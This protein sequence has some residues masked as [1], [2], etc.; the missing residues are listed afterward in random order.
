MSWASRRRSAYLSGVGIFLAVVIGI[1][2]AIWLYEAPTCFDGAQNQGETDIDK[3]GPCIIL[4]A[5]VL[6]P[7]S[8][9]WARSFES[10]PSFYSA[11]AYIENINKEAG[12]HAVGYRF[13]LYDSRNV[14]VA[15]RTGTTFVMPGGITPVFEGAIETGNRDVVRTYFEFTEIPVWERMTNAADVIRITNNEMK[16][17]ATMPRLSATVRNTSV[18]DVVDPSFVAVVSDP[19]GNAFAASAT[20]LQRLGAGEV[21]Q[22][23]FTWPT[24]FTSAVGRI[25][26]LPRLAPRT[27]R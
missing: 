19:A 24:A 18:S 27:A 20:T 9:L 5:R 17:E 25:D 14:L 8:I 11:V 7:V 16:D 26:I 4:D 3:G 15:E 2:L 10:R 21:G 1:P 22:V 13:G 12:I 6:Q 23:V